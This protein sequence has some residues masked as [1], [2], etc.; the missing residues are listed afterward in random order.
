MVVVTPC[1]AVVD[2]YRRVMGREV[3]LVG[4]ASTAPNGVAA[5]IRFRPKVVTL[6]VSL[7]GSVWD[8]TSA[9]AEET[10]GRSRVLIVG[11]AIT[12]FVADHAVHHGASGVIER[13][14]PTAEVLAAVLR[15]ARGREH[16][17]AKWERRVRQLRAE[18]PFDATVGLDATLERVL[19]LLAGDRGRQ[20]IAE[21]LDLDERGVRRMIAELRELVGASTDAGIVVRS[22]TGGLLDASAVASL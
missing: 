12:P 17:G 6:D 2:G 11:E 16:W 8:A 5:A 3:A 13:A 18:S 20:E 4:S 14:A 15:V 19:L 10:A 7:P 21:E 9:I 22:I 1:P